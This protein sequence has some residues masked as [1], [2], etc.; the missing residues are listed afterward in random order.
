MAG[1]PADAR[2]ADRVVLVTGGAR[3]MGAAHCRAFASEG[4]RVVVLDRR[5]DE[6]SALAGELGDRAVAME[7]DVGDEQGWA[8]VVEAVTERLD[9]VD[10]LVNNAGVGATTPL[11]ETSMAV[12]RRVTEVNQTGVFLGMRSVVPSMV[13]RGGGAIVN[14]SSI[15]GL[16]GIPISL[17][18]NASKF[19]VRGMTRSAAI[20]LASSNIRVN[21]VLPGY[22]RTTMLDVETFD[23][24]AGGTV[25]QGRLAEP[26]EITSAVLWLASDAAS[27]CNGTELVVDGGATAG[28]TYPTFQRAADAAL[29][30][31][32]S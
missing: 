30:P 2:F 6:A 32:R 23:S 18:Y 14:D 7:L 20:E 1:A 12:Y 22:V 8:D 25:P 28:P 29:D 3:G 17:A 26:E 15:A 9:G 31:H 4:A 11:V 13:R 21:A 27:Y 5:A 19:A 10:V 24:F 16:V